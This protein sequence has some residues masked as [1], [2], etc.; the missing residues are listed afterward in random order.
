MSGELASILASLERIEA[1]LKQAADSRSS[2]VLE[3]NSRGVNFAVKAYAGSPID[4]ADAAAR[5][6][7]EG[8]RRD[9]GA[10]A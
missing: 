1:L 2:V 4:E 5:A 7:F 3:T 9:Y 8:L 6:A 10:Q